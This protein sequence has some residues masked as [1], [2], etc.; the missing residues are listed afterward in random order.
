MKL[1]MVFTSIQTD[2]KEKLFFRMKEIFIIFQYL[3]HFVNKSIFVNSFY[4]LLYK[5][6]LGKEYR[7]TTIGNR[8]IAQAKVTLVE[9]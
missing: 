8:V 6:A 7:L 4:L 5:K 1:L 9:W 3:F 2:L